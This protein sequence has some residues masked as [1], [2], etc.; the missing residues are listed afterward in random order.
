MDIYKIT[1]MSHLKIIAARVKFKKIGGDF[2]KRW[3]MWFNLII[4]G[5]PYRCSFYLCNL[6]ELIF[7]CFNGYWYC[8]A[9]VSL[10]CKFTNVI[11][12]NQKYTE[13]RF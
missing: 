2:G 3:N 4:R 13:V 5:K 10:L 6:Y 9:V 12:D 8:M 7:N 11:L 1:L